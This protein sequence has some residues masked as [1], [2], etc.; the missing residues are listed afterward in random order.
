MHI[1]IHLYVLILIYT[2]IKY[3]LILIIIRIYIYISVLPQR[4]SMFLTKVNTSTTS[5][6]GSPLFVKPQGTTPPTRP[7]RGDQYG[8]WCCISWETWGVRCQVIEL[9]VAF[10]YFSP[11]YVF[12]NRCVIYIYIYRCMLCVWKRRMAIEKLKV[13]FA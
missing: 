5:E 2:Y 13:P 9:T 8:E 7:T 10:V 6:S 12:E 4:V 1:C 11:L 3:V